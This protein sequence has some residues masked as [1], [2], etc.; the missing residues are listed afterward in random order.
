MECCQDEARSKELISGQPFIY[1][2]IVTSNHNAADVGLTHTRQTDLPERKKMHKE[3]KT[4]NKNEGSVNK[5]ETALP[6]EMAQELAEALDGIFSAI[7]GEGVTSKGLPVFGVIDIYAEKVPDTSGD[8]PSENPSDNAKEA[9]GKETAE[10]EHED[11]KAPAETCPTSESR[12]K[13]SCVRNC[14]VCTVCSECV[15]HLFSDMILDLH[16]L[17]GMVFAARQIRALEANG[18][19]TQKQM[20]AIL[21]QYCEGASEIVKKWDGYLAPGE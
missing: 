16:S 7:F 15:G 19:V 18:G 12:E 9:P 11:L 4:M 3:M 2:G 21:K 10:P 17:K 13:I 5:L 14:S 20:D 1:C 6:P 8:T